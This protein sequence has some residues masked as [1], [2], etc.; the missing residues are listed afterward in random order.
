LLCF[1]FFA[2]EVGKV[3]FRLGH[4]ITLLIIMN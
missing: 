4:G 1:G 2:V 3:G